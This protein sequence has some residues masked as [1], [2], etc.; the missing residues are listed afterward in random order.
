MTILFCI[1]AFVL[2]ASLITKPRQDEREFQFPLT[3]VIENFQ[4]VEVS[5]QVK[6]L[7][8]ENLNLPK[9]NIIWPELID[10]SVY[11]TP[12]YFRSVTW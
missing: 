9:P 8:L 7:Q 5:P 10:Y 1:V 12:A 4:Q 6:T 3:P 2:I 11:D